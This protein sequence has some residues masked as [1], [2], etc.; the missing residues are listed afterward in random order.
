MTPGFREVLDLKWDVTAL[1]VGDEPAGILHSDAYC[2]SAGSAATEA[3]ADFIAF[4]NGEESQTV[5]A[6]SGRTVPSLKVVAESPAFLA[7]GQPPANAGAFV[8]GIPNIRFTPVIPTWT[9]I[10]DIAKDVLTRAF[11]DPA[12]SLDDALED[13]G[14]RTAPLFEEAHG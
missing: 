11:Y 2:L 1:P 8:N 4:A 12:Y 6:L 13:L 10:E 7:S 3:A 14:S 9:E 5:A